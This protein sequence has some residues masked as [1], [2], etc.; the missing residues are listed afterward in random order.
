MEAQHPLL[1]TSG[2]RPLSTQ[3]VFDFF[4]DTVPTFERTVIGRNAE[5]VA[6]LQC[7]VQTRDGNPLPAANPFGAKP[8][9]K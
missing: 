5:L 1:W 2:E 9:A 4:D 3:L 8:A 6:A 7:V